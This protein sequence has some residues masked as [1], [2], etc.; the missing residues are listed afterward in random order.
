MPVIRIES[1]VPP[2]CGPDPIE[3]MVTVSEDEVHAMLGFIFYRK[4]L[5]NL[6]FFAYGKRWIPRATQV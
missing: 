4:R 6:I 1:Y 3:V 2:L 5:Y